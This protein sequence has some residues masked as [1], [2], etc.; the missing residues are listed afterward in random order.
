[1]LIARSKK[2]RLGC[3]KSICHG[4]DAIWSEDHSK[5]EGIVVPWARRHWRSWG[6]TSLFQRPLRQQFFPCASRS[7]QRFRSDYSGPPPPAA[8]AWPHL[9]DA[10]KVSACRGPWEP[11]KKLAMAVSR[12]RPHVHA[13]VTCAWQSAVDSKATDDVRRAQFSLVWSVMALLLRP[14]AVSVSVVALNLRQ[15]WRLLLSC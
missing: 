15:L 7:R 10:A 11:R 9:Q 4:T 13:G 3:N 12:D 14:R 2:V 6:Y 5:T 1:M 8:V